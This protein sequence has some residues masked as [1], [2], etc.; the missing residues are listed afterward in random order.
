MC[1]LNIKNERQDRMHILNKIKSGL[2]KIGTN[3]YI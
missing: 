3:D 2:E 1:G